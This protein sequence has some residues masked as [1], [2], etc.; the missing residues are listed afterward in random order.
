MFNRQLSTNFNPSIRSPGSQLDFSWLPLVFFVLLST[1][2]HSFRSSVRS[3]CDDIPREMVLYLDGC[4]LRSRQCHLRWCS[5][6]K[7]LN[8]WTCSGGMWGSR[9]LYRRPLLISVNTSEEER[10]KYIGMTG[11][12]FE[13]FS[14]KS[15][16]E[17]C[18]GWGLF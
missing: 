7:R 6:H 11:T 10:P 14:L 16:K 15:N 9:N 12:F 13:R 18:G 17:Q 8:C 5:E 2:T 4:P 3:V 1:L